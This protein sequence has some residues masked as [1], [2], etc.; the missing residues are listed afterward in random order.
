MWIW[1]FSTQVEQS[2]F[3]ELEKRVAIAL[4]A[5]ANFYN[6]LVVAQETKGPISS[7]DAI[8]LQKYTRELKQ[9]C[10]KDGKDY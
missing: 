4:A 3:L 7:V 10:Q 5:L 9:R 2:G 1:L 8:L 6:R